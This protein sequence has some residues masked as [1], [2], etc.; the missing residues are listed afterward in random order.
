MSTGDSHLRFCGM[1]N[2]FEQLQTASDT[3]VTIFLLHH[4]FSLREF[5][6]ALRWRDPVTH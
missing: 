5:S 6:F 1:K 3:L 4:P 2:T